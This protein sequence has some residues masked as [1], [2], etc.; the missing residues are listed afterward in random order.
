M[1]MW[2]I[3]PRTMCRQHL[4]GEHV[5]CHMLAVCLRQGRNLDGYLERQLLEPQHVAARHDILVAE[6]EARG[7]RHRSPLEQ[8]AEPPSG[9]VPP[10]QSAA[11]LRGRCPA[12]RDRWR[13]RGT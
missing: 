12:C 9:Y 10:A 4:L 3:D 13:S 8:P 5:E 1:R 11:E 6:M 2:M 7:Y